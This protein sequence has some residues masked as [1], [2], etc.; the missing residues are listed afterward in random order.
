VGI[1][2]GDCTYLDTISTSVPR[3]CSRV[4]TH[5]WVRRWSTGY[6]PSTSLISAAATTTGE[7][8]RTGV[9]R[10][11]FSDL[12]RYPGRHEPGAAS[13][14]YNKGSQKRRCR[15]WLR[16]LRSVEQ[17]LRMRTGSYQHHSP[18]AHPIIPIH[19]PYGCQLNHALTNVR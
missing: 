8:E 19:S 15:G 2:D 6:S 11:G 1:G 4:T 7:R 14:T 12:K 18:P 13:N 3:K 9:R 5:D 16:E 17:L 10:M